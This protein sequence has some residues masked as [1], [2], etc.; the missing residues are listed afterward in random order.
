MPS[1]PQRELL[2][3]K[4]FAFALKKRTYTDTHPWVQ[5]FSHLSE[6]LPRRAMNYAPHGGFIFRAAFTGKI[7]TQVKTPQ[8]LQKNDI[9]IAKHF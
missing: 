9:S 4:V 2:M 7:K 3:S 1:E 6:S 8:I 5:T